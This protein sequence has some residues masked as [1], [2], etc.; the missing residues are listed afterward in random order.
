MSQHLV[1]DP[2]NPDP[3]RVLVDWLLSRGYT[4]ETH[5]HLLRDM[6]RM[7]KEASAAANVTMDE[8]ISCLF[9]FDETGVTGAEI[10]RK[11]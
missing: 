7:F 5:P 10:T 11:D 3:S 4:P 9:T 6:E 1:L 2:T 8:R